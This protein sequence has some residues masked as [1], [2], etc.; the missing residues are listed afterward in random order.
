MFNLIERFINR[1]TLEDVNNF[2]LKNGI[3]L[4][5]DELSFTYN[6]IKKNYK[7]MLL[8][9]NLFDINKY[10][11]FYSKENFSK[12]AKVYQEYFNKYSLYL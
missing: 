10:Q 7:E 8:N 1:M 2:A 4:N 5:S 6:F 12:I 11:N 3:T 9:P